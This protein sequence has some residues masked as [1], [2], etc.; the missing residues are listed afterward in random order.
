MSDLV[1]AWAIDAEWSEPQ[2]IGPT[3][4][5]LAL[6]R[7]QA[8][9]GGF[10]RPVILPD[11]RIDDGPLLQMLVNEEPKPDVQFNHRARLLHPLGPI[12]GTVLIV[13]VKPVFD[14]DGHV[15]DLQWVDVTKVVTDVRGVHNLFTLAWCVSP[16]WTLPA[17]DLTPPL[18]A[19]QDPLRPVY[20]LRGSFCGRRSVAPPATAY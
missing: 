20:G 7:F 11:F 4:P 12:R 8:V 2:L 3:E 6:A 16:W 1:T 14:D 18:L 9:V 17:V 5:D 13:A 19:S 15:E 10:V